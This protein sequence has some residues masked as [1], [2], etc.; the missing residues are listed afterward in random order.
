MVSPRSTLATLPP[1]IHGARNYGELACLGLSPDAVIDFS[2][3]SNPYGPHPAVQAAVQAAVAAPV[4]AH[5][6]DREC[7]ALRA[8]LAAAEGVSMDNILPGNGAAELIQLAALAFVTPGSRHLI[9]SPT[10]GEYSRAIQLMGGQALEVRPTHPDLRFEAAEVAAAI[11]RLR[12]ESVWL[13]QPNNPTGQLWTAAELT[14]LRAADPDARMLWVVD[15]SYHY[16]VA[17]PVSLKGEIEQE[18]LLIL[19]SLTKDMALAGL[20]LGYALAAPSLIQSLR[21]VQPPWSVNSLAQVAGA[22]ALQAEVLTWRQKSIT[23]LHSNAA[24][25]WAGLTEL[26]LMIL[27]TQTTFALVNVGHAAEFR[28]RL[29]AHGLLVRDCT[30]FGLPGHIRIA[31]HRPEEN[32]QLLKAIQVEHSKIEDGKWRIEEKR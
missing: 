21:Q 20:R 3:N 25:L 26:E 10:F 27:P 15:E 32:W 22:A 19:R 7:L 31:A 14:Y 30:S 12:P 1:S 13:C 9:V 29:L 16:F 18:N 2:A 17:N 8:A 24:E 4:L 6:P 23:Q 5:Y 11:H 28:R